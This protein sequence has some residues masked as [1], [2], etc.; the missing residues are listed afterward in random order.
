MLA[1]LNDLHLGAFIRSVDK[2]RI[3][4]GRGEWI[5]VATGQSQ[6][7]SSRDVNEIKQAYGA[8]VVRDTARRFA[9]F[10]WVTKQVDQPA[11]AVRRV[12]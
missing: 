3:H 4:F 2:G 11:W 7:A 12:S 1:A 9:R 10:G 8:A 6:F 5:D